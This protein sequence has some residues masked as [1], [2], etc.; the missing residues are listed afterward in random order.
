[1]TASVAPPPQRVSPRLRLLLLGAGCLAG[2]VA[3]WHVARLPLVLSFDLAPWLTLVVAFLAAE[4]AQ[5]H[6]EVRKQT[7]SMS[8]SELPLVLGT[9]LLG[10]LAT[11]SSRVL[12]SAIAMLLRRDPPTKV[13]INLCVFALESTVF[14]A[15]L[16]SFSDRDILTPQTWAAIMI[17]VVIALLLSFSQVTVIVGW[18]QG[19]LS[20]RRLIQIV[21]PIIIVGLISS[22]T[23]IVVAIVLRT[24]PAGVAL[25]VALGL[26][27]ALGFRGYARSVQQHKT[28][29]QVYDF[30]KKV[31]QST[32]L[33]A[34]DHLVVESVRE[35]LN[36]ERA[37]LWLDAS[38]GAPARIAFATASGGDVVYPG[39][40]DLGDPLRE[41]VLIEGS[42]VLF[43]SR[44][45]SS[46]ERGAVTLRGA[47][48]VIAVPLLSAQGTIGFLEVCDRR[49]DK[50]AFGADDV[51]MLE[52]LATHVS[53]AA[54]NVHL[55]RKLRF[56][57]LHDRLTGLPNR[58]A[59]GEIVGE[60][61]ADIEV[62]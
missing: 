50:L 23:A 45:G 14:S 25:L 60:L 12:G 54:Q 38:D 1:M 20:S 2:T 16:Y 41:R 17:A 58:L 30:A 32:T 18:T 31:E 42:G 27:F 3:L 51:R 61:L 22:A 34:S 37:A 11:V 55:M 57:A 26:V 7:F 43:G 44:S 53:A 40:D 36:A 52:S 8:L 47:A 62:E 29:G 4:L 48:E 21:S 24:D 6:I 46:I 13:A 56:D 5:F 10:P 35:E 33:S 19:W 49:G 59:L 39:P 9:I 15:V 28:L